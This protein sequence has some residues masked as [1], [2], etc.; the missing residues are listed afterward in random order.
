MPFKTDISPAT[1][2]DLSRTAR[3]AFPPMG[4]YIIRDKE[5]GQVRV[6]SSRNVVGAMNRIQFELRLRSH[7]DKSLQVDW[8][9]SG[10]TR[11][12]F[13]VVEL[14]EEREDSN[15]DYVVELRTLEQIYR[16]QYQ[17][18]AGATR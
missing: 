3:D 17:L 10:P 13:E 1:R 8:N 7:T 4:V 5:T 14:L 12:D 15:F 16:E 18:E 2:R 9:R 11:F 6:A